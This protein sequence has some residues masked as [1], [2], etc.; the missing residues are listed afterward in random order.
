M[1]SVKKE[2]APFKETSFLSYLHACIINVTYPVDQVLLIFITVII[3][4]DEKVGRVKPNFPRWKQELYIYTTADVY[5]LLWVFSKFH[6]CTVFNSLFD[7]KKLKLSEKTPR[8]RYW[9]KTIEPINKHVEGNKTEIY[10]YCRRYHLVAICTWPNMTS[11]SFSI[12]APNTST[13]TTPLSYRIPPVAQP[14]PT[15]PPARHNPIPPPA[16]HNLIPLHR[17]NVTPLLH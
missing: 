4:F 13:S 7:K 14:N 11:T 8:D 10:D 1:Y 3:N 9:M 6:W 15:S 5:L 2:E 16:Q 17:P 12:S